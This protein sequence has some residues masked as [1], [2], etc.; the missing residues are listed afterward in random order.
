MC[1]IFTQSKR[2]DSILALKLIME[3]RGVMGYIPTRK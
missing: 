1:K 2:L 3:K